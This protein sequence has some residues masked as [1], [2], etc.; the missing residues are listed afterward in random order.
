MGGVLD[1]PVYSGGQAKPFGA[2]TLDEVSARA[3]ELRASGGG[4]PLARVV[5]VAMAWAEL[6]RAMSAA[7]AATVDDLDHAQIEARAERL[8]IIPPGGSLLP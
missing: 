7:G 4:G 5:P 3:A 8:W 6:A 2:L 1:Q